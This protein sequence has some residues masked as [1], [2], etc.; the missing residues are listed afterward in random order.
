LNNKDAKRIKADNS[1]SVLF[2]GRDRGHKIAS[3]NSIKTSI[4]DIATAKPGY[5]IPSGSTLGAPNVVNRAK[6][7]LEAK[8]ATKARKSS[9]SVAGQIVA[10]ESS[11][12]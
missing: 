1:F 4:K 9:L 11:L 10:S 7:D 5:E 12:V 2:D 3:G 8:T 6:I